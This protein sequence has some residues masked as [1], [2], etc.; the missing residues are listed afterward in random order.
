MKNQYKQIP[1]ILEF[2]YSNAIGQMF[3]KKDK[4]LPNA[5]YGF[6]CV[7]KVK[8][9]DGNVIKEADLVAISL[10]SKINLQKK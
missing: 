8:K 4:L 2:D 3:I 9:R 6:E 7:F 10:V 1:I 5:K